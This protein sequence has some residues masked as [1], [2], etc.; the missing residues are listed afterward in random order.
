MKI[1]TKVRYGLRVMMELGLH[2]NKSGM[3]QK[4]IAHNQKLSEK[5]LDPIIAALKVSG[6]IMN[7]SGKKSG[8]FIGKS[9]SEITVYDIYRTFEPDFEISHCPKIPATCFIKRMCV[10]NEIWMGLN[11]VMSNY[12]KKITLDDIIKKHKK[13]KRYIAEENRAVEHLK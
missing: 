9:K 5:Y 12:L 13:I 4:E 11:D 7:F 1:N 3:Y 6:L 10:A 2:D 8:Y